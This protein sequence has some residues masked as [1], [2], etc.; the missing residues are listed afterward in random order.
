MVRI[1]NS[2][3]TE[4]VNETSMMPDDAEIFMRKCE[5]FFAVYE[6]ER[7]IDWVDNF[8]NPVTERMFYEE[9]KNRL[10]ILKGKRG[11]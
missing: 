4:L 5:T 3:I 10:K 2:L 1:K 6:I 11:V 8:Y 9:L 7:L